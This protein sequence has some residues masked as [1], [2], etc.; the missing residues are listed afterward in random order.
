MVL[1]T[2]TLLHNPMHGR[3][4]RM[5][6]SF[7]MQARSCWLLLFFLLFCTQG[8]AQNANCSAATE[9]PVFSG[10]DPPAGTTLVTYTIFGELLNQVVAITITIGGADVPRNILTRSSS[11]IQ[12]R[13]VNPSSPAIANVSLQPN[14]SACETLSRT[15]S[16]HRSRKCMHDVLQ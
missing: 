13:F 7:N 4:L 6:A 8:S 15:V 14:N 11:A 16:L 3:N 2:L 10:I 1:L 9:Q 5:A 12:F